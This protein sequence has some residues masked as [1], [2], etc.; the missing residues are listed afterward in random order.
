MPFEAW[1]FCDGVMA[2]R[3]N[4]ALV[5]RDITGGKVHRDVEPVH[6]L[7]G[8][9]PADQEAQA[10]IVER[11]KEETVSLYRLVGAEAHWEPIGEL[12]DFVRTVQ[13]I[14]QPVQVGD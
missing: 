3:L 12:F 13:E 2:I 6:L 14:E 8:D 5:W 11:I 10:A 9:L 7:D 4:A 1:Q